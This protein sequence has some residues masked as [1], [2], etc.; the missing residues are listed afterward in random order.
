[1]S[2]AI[3]YAVYVIHAPLLDL[4]SLFT[5]SLVLEIGLGLSLIFVLGWLLEY[6]FQPFALGRLAGR[7]ES[8]SDASLHR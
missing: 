8:R 4:M 7:R 2:G 1:M 6:R 5:S 3:S